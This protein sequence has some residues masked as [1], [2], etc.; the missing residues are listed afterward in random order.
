M[1]I[2]VTGG[3][4]FVGSHLVDRLVRRGDRVVVLDDLSS[5][6]T[7][8]LAS[9]AALAD[10]G[11]LQLVH[12]CV[13]EAALVR[14]LCGEVDA[15]FHLAAVVGVRRS[16]EQATL[17]M[18]VNAEGTARV[19]EACAPARTPLLLTS[20]SEV[21][22][23]SLEPL[24]ED[25]PV[26]PGASER[27]RG[28][29]A[30]SKAYGEWLALAFAREQGLPVVVTRLFNVIGPRQSQAMVVPRF[31]AQA[32]RGEALTIHGDGSQRRCF[33]DVGEVADALLALAATPAARG[34]VVNV[35]GTQE[36]SVRELARRVLAAAGL[37]LPLRTVS[38]SEAFPPGGSDIR[39]RVP[40]LA[41]LRGL[42]GTVP[43]RPLDETLRELVT[44][45]RRC[46]DAALLAP[47]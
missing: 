21:Y 10:P 28:G 40:V 5:G 31:V 16:L 1:R 37:E 30:C 4:G 45:Q 39:R 25:S 23:D 2:L 33:A 26:L 34:R 19:L 32:L 46:R 27:M 8:H 43:S 3:A 44:E 29:Y 9:A 22:G 35:G 11:A 47:V 36:C 15:V 20:S 13:T 41:L 42:I 12:G 18:R 38:A 7:Q 6:R 14:R 17:A 24:A